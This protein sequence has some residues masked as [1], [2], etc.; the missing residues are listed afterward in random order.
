M[1]RYG[2]EQPCRDLAEQM[3]P[4][5]EA[6]LPDLRSGADGRRVGGPGRPGGE[7]VAHLGLRQQPQVGFCALTVHVLQC[8]PPP[9]RR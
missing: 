1:P 9:R 7:R 6:G 2:R 5:T 8:P 3:L 4:G